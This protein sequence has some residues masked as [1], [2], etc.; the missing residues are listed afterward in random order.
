MTCRSGRLESNNQGFIP[1]LSYVN[2]CIYFMTEPE[3]SSKKTCTTLKT[4]I[5]GLVVGEIPEREIP[6][7]KSWEIRDCPFNTGL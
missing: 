7:G 3:N 1:L 5:Q 6:G 2:E 4:V